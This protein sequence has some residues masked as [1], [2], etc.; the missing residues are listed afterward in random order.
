MPVR[1]GF[2]RA[3]VV[4]TVSIV[5]F[6]TAENALA[7]PPAVTAQTDAYNVGYYQSYR[8]QQLDSYQIS[9]GYKPEHCDRQ[10]YGARLGHTRN[11]P[12]NR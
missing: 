11:D 6:A 1:P 12:E 8:A 7:A 3:I 4:V 5:A 9:M 10:R 2:P